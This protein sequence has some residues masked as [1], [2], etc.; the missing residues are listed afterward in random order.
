MSEGGMRRNSI[1]GEELRAYVER[2]ERL[3]EERKEVS[4]G[5]G[6]VYAEAKAKGYTPRYMKA[7][8]RLRALPPSQ[9]QED[10]AL[11]ELYLGALGMAQEPP[12]FRTVGAMGIDPAARESVLEAIKLLAP[13]NGE[14]ILKCGGPAVRVW[15]DKDGVA[16]VEEVVDRPEPSSSTRPA[17]Q[18]KARPAIDLPDVDEDGAEELGRSDAQ[19][20]KP[21]IANP[22][23][24]DDKRRARWD[25]GWRKATGSDGMG[26]KDD[27][28]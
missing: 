7:L 15:R 17:R 24:W 18:P 8:V 28:E 26:P 27:D 1:V 4:D 6:A 20:D 22:F 23:P 25:L 10:E 21:I 16:Q 12:L 2:V 9:R 11:M 13:A 5:I 19:A 3:I 14:I